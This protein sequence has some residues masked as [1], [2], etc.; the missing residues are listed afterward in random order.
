MYYH[1]KF[2]A[3]LTSIR[4][5]STVS[6]RFTHTKRLFHPQSFCPHQEIISS[7]LNNSFTLEHQ[8]YTIAIG[9]YWRP[10]AMGAVVLS[11]D[12]VCVCVYSS[13]F[14]YKWGPISIHLLIKYFLK[15]GHGPH[16]HYFTIQS[17]PSTN[18]YSSKERYTFD[19]PHTSCLSQFFFNILLRFSCLS[20]SYPL[21]QIF[22]WNTTQ[23][24]GSRWFAATLVWVE[25]HP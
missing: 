24:G 14:I 13:K 3:V 10:F 15:S 23:N 25:C 1:Y 16:V 7:T 8:K 19:A 21:Y 2:H 12:C 22:P 18:Q 17:I 4:H 5:D 9:C 6:S 20:Q 11:F